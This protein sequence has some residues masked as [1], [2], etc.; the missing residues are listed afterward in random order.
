MT[1]TFHVTLKAMEL[2]GRTEVRMELENLL[3][4]MGLMESRK[5]LRKSEKNY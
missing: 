5:T 4:K 3:D 1:Q 2:Q